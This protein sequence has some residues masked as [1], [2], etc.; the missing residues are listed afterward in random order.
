[1]SIPGPPCAEDFAM[2]LLLFMRGMTCI[3]NEGDG[4]CEN[5][6]R[7][8]LLYQAQRIVRYG[9]CDAY[10][11]DSNAYFFSDHPSQ[12]LWEVPYVAAYQP[13]YSVIL[14][15]RYETHE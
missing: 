6:R 1:M 10:R 12:K 4:W 2:K 13:S 11:S 3:R 15:T 8:G 14:S 7:L 9:D 5:I